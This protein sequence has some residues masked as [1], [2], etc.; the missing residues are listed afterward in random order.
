[1]NRKLLLLLSA[2]VAGFI[3]LSAGLPA[4]RSASTEDRE[5]DRLV[6]EK[7]EHWQDWK[8]GLMMHWGPYSQWGVVESW[9]LCSEDEPWCRRTMDNYV[10]YK[11]AYE[12]LPRT[13]NPAKFDPA[14]WAAAAKAAGMRYVVFTTKHHDGFSMF[15]TKETD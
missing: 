1:M 12:A 9:T 2:A 13:F 10:E 3:L 6:L 15:D 14:K 11:K 8:F 5:T 4:S 7:L